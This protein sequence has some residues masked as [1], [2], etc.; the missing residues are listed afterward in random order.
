MQG[1]AVGVA[2]NWAQNAVQNWKQI[3]AWSEY[4]WLRHGFTTRRGGV[5]R[6]YAGDGPAELNLGF[7]PEDDPDAVRQNRRQAVTAVAGEQAE[8][9]TVRQVHGTSVLAVTTGGLAGEADGLVTGSPGVVLGVMTA[10]CVPILLADVRRQLVGA[11]HAGWRG[12]AA[13]IAGVGVA[14]MLE[15][16]AHGEDL[17]AAIGPSIG[18]C[19]YQV[20]DEVRR[21]FL[22]RAEGRAEGAAGLFQGES[23][24]RLDLWESNRRQLVQAGV[25]AGRVSLVAECTACTRLPDGRRKYFSHRAEHGRTGRAMGLIGIAREQL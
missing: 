5:S 17:V 2:E 21:A 11:L 22:D 10:D 9:A 12:T 13:G 6:V 1:E 18:P 15:M 3:A 20:G 7:T 8:L 14:R 19:C 16:G 4:T 23:L 25:P 24:D